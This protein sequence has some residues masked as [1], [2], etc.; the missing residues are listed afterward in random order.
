MVGVPG[1]VS[2]NI[3]KARSSSGLGWND[4]AS[5]ANYFGHYSTSNAT[6]RTRT[7]RKRLHIRIAVSHERATPI[8]KSLKG[9]ASR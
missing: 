2:R 5:I 6:P 9:V 1:V 4:V 7:T 8:P 3:P